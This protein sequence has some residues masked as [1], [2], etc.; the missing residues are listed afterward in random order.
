MNNSCEIYFISDFSNQFLVEQLIRTGKEKELELLIHSAPIDQIDHQISNQFSNYFSKDYDFVVLLESS[1][2]LINEYNSSKKH[3]QFADLAFKRIK[4]LLEK[5]LYSKKDKIILGNYYELN[6]HV[7]GQFSS[8]YESSF[9]FQLRK[10]NFLIS[11]FVKNI[12]RISIFDIST[13]QNEI[14]YRNLFNEA[15][16]VNYEMLF[17]PELNSLLS[18]YILDVILVN[19]SKFNKCLVLDLDNTL[20]GGIIGDDGIEN[21]QIGN[22]GAGK[23]FRDF[24][25]W[26]KKLKNRGVILCVCSKNEEDVAKN[27]F[28]NHPEMILKLEDFSIF[29]ANWN[30][31]V[32]NIR[33]I[34]EVLNIGFDSMV[35]LD[36]NPYERNSIKENLQEITVPDLPDDPA[37]Y[38]SFLYRENLFETKS[39][40]SFDAQRNKLYQTEYERVKEKQNYTDLSDYMISLKMVSNLSSLNKFNIPRVAQL[41]QRSNQFNLRTIRYSTENLEIIKKSK[42]YFSLIFDLHDKFGDHGIISYLIVKINSDNSIFIENWAMSCRV[43]ERGMEEFIFNSIIDYCQKN[44]INKVFAEYIETKKNKIVKNLYT[45][46]GFDNINS[47]FELD[48]KKAVKLKTYIKHSNG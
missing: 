41:S 6:D 12:E 24:Q 33:K 4:T 32:D 8:K 7:F 3:S 20:W 29:I 21:I 47:N 22:L 13:V 10:L 37:N 17:N 2:K 25:L 48:I 43:L 5:I 26:I 46:L 1:H 27:V 38:L 31:K 45:N 40:N 11:D 15:L 30:S 34:Q 19:K 44:K 9:I 16:Y 42:K 35:F 18:K 23:A 39:I 28:E 14:G 36:D